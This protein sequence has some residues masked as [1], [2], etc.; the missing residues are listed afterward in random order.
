MVT[1]K[2]SSSKK[3]KVVN[4]YGEWIFP[5]VYLGQGDKMVVNLFISQISWYGL[6][7]FYFLLLFREIFL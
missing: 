7:T 3:K 4:R 5:Q 2:V 6:H 1:L